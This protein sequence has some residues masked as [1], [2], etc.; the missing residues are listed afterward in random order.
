[1]YNL[2]K[3]ALNI[4]REMLEMTMNLQELKAKLLAENISEETISLIEK[5]MGSTD[6]A[7]TEALMARLFQVEAELAQSRIEVMLSQVKPHFIFN[8]MNAIAGLIRID[9]ERAYK[10][11]IVFSQYLR[12]NLDALEKKTPIT[13]EQELQNI[14]LYVDLENIRFANRINYTT[15]IGVSNFSL[16]TLTIEPLVESAVKK[17]LKTKRY[18]GNVELKTWEDGD[19]IQIQ[20]FDDGVGFD[21]EHPDAERQ[22]I[23][24]NV[25]CRLEYMEHAQ[26]TVESGLEEG[27]RIRITLPKSR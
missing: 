27:T 11:V 21:A 16:P 14:Q 8:M 6:S 17:G 10:T 18:K 20:V 15:D 13:F 22:R 12:N 4:R 7:N 24:D 1:M 3:L 5:E 25:R 9:P 2:S 19:C 23:Y 26:F